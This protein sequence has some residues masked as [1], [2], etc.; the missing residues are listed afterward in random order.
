MPGSD[1]VE[2]SFSIRA[3][4]CGNG[5]ESSAVLVD[6]NAA[7]FAGVSGIRISVPSADA[8]FNLW[9]GHG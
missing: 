1:R 6:P 4:S 2:A 8:A 7:R 5:A 3:C 9:I